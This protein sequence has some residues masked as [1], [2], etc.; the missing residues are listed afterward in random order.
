VTVLFDED[1]GRK[2]TA[3]IKNEDRRKPGN[4]VSPSK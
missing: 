3:K 4:E 1:L 2:I